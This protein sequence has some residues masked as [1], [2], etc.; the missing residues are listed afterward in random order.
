LQRLSEVKIFPKEVV[1]VKKAILKGTLV[2]QMLL[3]GKEESTLGVDFSKRQ[4]ISPKLNLV[5]S[6]LPV[7]NSLFS[8][9]FY[10]NI[11]KQTEGEQQQHIIIQQAK[12]KI[13]F[14]YEERISQVIMLDIIASLH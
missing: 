7:I 3:Q 6:P 5:I 1:Q 10:G 9:S 2:L 4:K 14:Q 8:F 11:N 13:S 12:T